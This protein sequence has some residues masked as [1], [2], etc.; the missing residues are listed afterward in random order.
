MPERE[1][2]SRRSAS[3]LPSCPMLR[4]RSRFSTT[5]C[6][7]PPFRSCSTACPQPSRRSRRRAT[8]TTLWSPRRRRIPASLELEDQ[9]NVSSRILELSRP[10]DVDT[11]I[12]VARERDF[13]H[14]VVIDRVPLRRDAR[15]TLRLYTL[16]DG[17]SVVG[18]A[19]VDGTRGI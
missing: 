11:A 18:I 17:P 6:S 2:W 9:L 13:R 1:W 16:T 19:T 8:L 15:V 14:T 3:P 12:P 5:G 7:P 10:D 4:G